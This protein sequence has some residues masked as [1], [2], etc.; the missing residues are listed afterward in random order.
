MKRVPDETEEISDED[1]EIRE[2]SE[3]AV[4]ILG[5]MENM[6]SS[7]MKLSAQAG[8]DKVEAEERTN[9][10]PRRSTHATPAAPNDAKSDAKVESPEGFGFEGSA[11]SAA[12]PFPKPGQ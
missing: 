6:T 10:R 12:L 4:R 11:P 3:A 2:Q 9:K 5:G 7:L 8:K 1:V